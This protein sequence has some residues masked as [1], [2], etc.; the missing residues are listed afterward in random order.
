MCMACEE[1][2][3][4]LPLP[5]R[6][7]VERGEIRRASSR[8]ISRRAGPAGRR[9]EARAADAEPPKPAESVRLRR[10]GRA[11]DA[12]SRR[13]PRRGARRPAQAQQFSAAELADAHL[14][15]IEQARALNAYVLETPERGARHGEGR[16]RAARK[17]RRAAARRHP[18]RHQ[19][20][21]RTK[22]VRTTACSH[23]LDNF[24]PTYESTVT[25]QLWRDGAVH[26]RQA[27]QRRVRHGLV[28]R[29]LVLRPGDQSRGGA[30]ARTRRWCR[31]ARPAARRRRWRRI[32]ASARPAPTPAARSASRRRSP[33]SSA[34]SRPTGA[35]RAG[36][37]SRSP[38][39]STRPGRFART[40][41]DAAILLRSMAGH[42][43]KDTTS[44]DRAGAGLRGGASA[45][46]SRA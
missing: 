14:A 36:A 38:R 30:R 24:V 11:N 35:A 44:V 15:A 40:V 19:G 27:Q 7:A 46:R 17:R 18:A 33:A 25:A 6:V 32:S 1:E 22:G 28:E 4:W 5:A 21:V 20:P 2:A 8:R 37:S 26:A 10:S 43:P 16:R 39:R 29:D 31:A 45:S 23:I 41:R 9:R 12:S 42:D 13:S 34:S 3:L